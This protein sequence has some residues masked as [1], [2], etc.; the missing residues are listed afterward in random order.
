LQ[1]KLQNITE[2]LDEFSLLRMVKLRMLA[3]HGAFEL[4]ILLLLIT[5]PLLLYLGNNI[6][7]YFLFLLFWILNAMRQCISCTKFYICA[8]SF[9]VR[10]ENERE[11]TLLT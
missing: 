5:T 8:F 1:E 6:F 3:E 7:F 11:N 10:F 4:L 2:K 9:K